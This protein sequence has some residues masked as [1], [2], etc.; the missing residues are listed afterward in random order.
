MAMSTR[1][2]PVFILVDTSG[3]MRGEPI[4][5]L[6]VGLKTMEQALRRDP[7]ALE[8]VHLSLIT[9]DLEVRELFPLTPLDQV[10]IP[11]IEVPTS[12]ATFL[13]AAL[14]LLVERVDRDV[15]QGHLGSEDVRGQ[16]DVLPVEHALV[17]CGRIEIEV[18]VDIGRRIDCVD[19]RPVHVQDLPGI[20]IDHVGVI[21]E[22]ATDGFFQ[23]HGLNVG[24]CEING[25]S[26]AG[27]AAPNNQDIKITRFFHGITPLLNCIRI[28]QALS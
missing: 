12:G 28:N 11:E 5:A 15:R 1:R 18:E 20:Y 17:L 13:G 23:N 16:G 10:R 26:H 2:L 6:N 24:S 7:F 8:S 27:N 14:K 19:D 4:Q 25:R 9:F 3:S 21:A 22:A